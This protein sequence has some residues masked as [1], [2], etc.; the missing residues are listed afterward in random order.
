MT[1]TTSKNIEKDLRI[2]GR[3]LANL[4]LAEA[5]LRPFINDWAHLEA[6]EEQLFRDCLGKIIELEHQ[7]RQYENYLYKQLSF[8]PAVRKDGDADADGVERLQD[9]QP[10]TTG[11]QDT[12]R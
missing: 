2:N 5:A 9:D 11:E 12:E 10:A 8:A 4:C 7:S 1:A 3:F 6:E